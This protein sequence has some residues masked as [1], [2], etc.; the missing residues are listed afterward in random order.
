LP[1]P[2]PRRFRPCQR[3]FYALVIHEESPAPRLAQ[4]SRMGK[5]PL[6]AGVL[7]GRAPKD[8][9]ANAGLCEVQRRQAVELDE[10]SCRFRPAIDL[11]K[12]VPPKTHRAAQAEYGRLAA[13]AY[14]P[15]DAI[16]QAGICLGRPAK[17][18]TSRPMLKRNACR[19]R[20]LSTVG[21]SSRLSPAVGDPAR[22]A[23]CGGSFCVP[24]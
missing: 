13:Q 18:S 4:Q 15:S 7:C 20:I 11:R 23:P 16:S 1:F 12:L 22:M 14:S 9:P 19:H 5:V 21:W 17:G 10:L 8:R 24:A 2:D 3:I 6:F